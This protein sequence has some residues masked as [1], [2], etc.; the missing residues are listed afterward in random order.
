[1]ST[2]AEKRAVRKYY[3]THKEKIAARIKITG[4][5]YRE[6][7]KEEIK[8]RY[9]KYYKKH[10]EE[11][12]KYQKE[13]HKKHREEILKRNKVYALA[14][15]EIISKQKKDYY[16]KHKKEIIQQHKKFQKANAKE[17]KKK[18]KIWQKKY[19]TTHHTKIL[20]KQKEYRLTNK[21]KLSKVN[22]EY[23]INNRDKSARWA[24]ERRR[25][26]LNTRIKNV[27]SSRIRILIKQKST[28][29]AG[30]TL[31][32]LGCT[33][34]YFKKHIESQFKEGM[35]WDNYGKYGWHIDHIIPCASFNLS[36]PEQQKK[37]FHY[38]NLQPLGWL[39]NIK[40]GTKILKEYISI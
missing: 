39:D 4:K 28:T 25:I 30:K 34:D 40:K 5:K 8:E 33:L 38:T 23:K 3:E 24:R 22:H 19:Y 31:E 27:L 10:K 7:H 32:L 12:K 16:E 15:P 11:L 18:N 35:S 21:E 20:K 1:M 14:H 37:C 2:E 29:K 26:D 36:D 17:F 13:Y 9:K 6:T